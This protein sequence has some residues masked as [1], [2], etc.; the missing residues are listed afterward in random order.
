MMNLCFRK[1]S[2]R[3]SISESIDELLDEVDPPVRA[4][5]KQKSSLSQQQSDV[6]SLPAKDK[7][8]VTNGK[9]SGSPEAKQGTS[10]GF[11]PR[12][13]AKLPK[14]DKKKEQSK[15]YLKTI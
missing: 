4:T 13:D 6:E 11:Q 15:R 5:T 3:V 9:G 8:L 2:R 7:Y 1:K 12:D 10:K 14:D